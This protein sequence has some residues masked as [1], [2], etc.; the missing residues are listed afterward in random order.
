MAKRRRKG[1]IKQLVS[2][3][4]VLAG[5]AVGLAIVGGTLVVPIIGAI[6]NMIV[7]WT[8]VAGGTLEGLNKFGIKL[9]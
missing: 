1:P 7:G 4:S 3:T 8:V 6:G 9:F 5:V 2:W